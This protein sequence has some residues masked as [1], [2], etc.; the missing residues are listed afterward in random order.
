MHLSRFKLGGSA[1][2]A[3]IR[4]PERGRPGARA[5]VGGWQPDVVQHSKRLLNQ[6]PLLWFLLSIEM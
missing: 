3:S 1:T 5:T 2:G 6:I 4:T